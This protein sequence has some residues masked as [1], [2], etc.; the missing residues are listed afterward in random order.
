MGK[1]KIRF[2]GYTEDWEQRKLSDIVSVLDGDRGKNYPTE[3]DFME[4]G[5][6]IFL[7]ASNI[8]NSG[9]CFDNTQ[10]ITEDKSNSLGNGKLVEGDIV[11]TSRG[12]LGHICWYNAGIARK[13]PYARINSGML[14]LRNNAEID[15]AFLHQYLKSD[16]GQSQISFMSFGSAQP[17]LTKKGVE[18][19]SIVFPTK[20]EEQK[21]IGIYFSNLDT[22]ITLHHRKQKYCKKYKKR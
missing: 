19:M 21:Q 10:F 14:I 22:L 12:S 2:K 20:E 15:T 11:V 6:T 3:A 18:N 17:Q 9:F 16:K 13:I 5:H 8:T 1:P 4:D 7:N